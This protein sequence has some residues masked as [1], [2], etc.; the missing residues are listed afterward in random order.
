MSNDL[1]VQLGARLDQFQSDLNQA[2]AEQKPDQPTFYIVRAMM[3]GQ[4]KHH[5]AVFDD[6]EEAA[7][8]V[9]WL[10]PRAIGTIQTIES[11]FA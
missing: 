10:T 8:H 5:L 9:I 7:D 2:V 11:S 6:P 4:A 1:I 3:P